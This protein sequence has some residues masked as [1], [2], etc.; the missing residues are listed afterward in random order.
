M[1]ATVTDSLKRK[2]LEVI[3]NEVTNNLERYYVGVGRSDAWDDAGDNPTTP[4]NSV[5][6]EREFRL[7]WQSVKRIVDVS[8][9]VPRHNWT[10]GSIYSRYDDNYSSYPTYPYY[11]LTDDNQVYICLKQSTNDE[12]VANPSTSKP[13]TTNVGT[14]QKTADGYI[15][16][17]LYT[18]GGATANK[19]L[20]A[21]YMPVEYIN[22]SSGGIGL[23]GLQVQ[24]AEVRENAIPKQVLGWVVDSGGR[25]FTSAP[26]IT[27]V[28]N[29]DSVGIDA[30]TPIAGAV[31]TIS[32]SVISKVEVDSSLDSVAAFG[33]NY[34]YA[35]VTLSGGGGTGSVI[36]PILGPDSG[37]GANPVKDLRSASIMFNVKPSGGEDGA[38]GW[39][40]WVVNEQDYRQVALVY[41]PNKGYQQ[42]YAGID[43]AYTEDTG[44]V[45]P[46]L[47]MSSPADAGQFTLDQTVTDGTATGLIVDIDSDRI[48]Y[49]QNIDT[50]FNRFE[51]SRQLTA[52]GLGN[53]DIDSVVRKGDIDPFS[54]EIMYLENRAA[55]ERI[56]GQVEDVKIII[57]L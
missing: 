47:V 56:E 50:G 40:D 42:Y 37:I 3:Y 55:V 23:T 7:G 34:D 4:T 18:I 1:P 19:F 14:V 20:S 10:S 5:L 17:F 30:N 27:I 52:D 2:F 48:Y 33:R 25:D 45:S 32:G 46:Y 53:F 43:S 44:R 21:N 24:Q 9:V 31:A 39:R 6:N 41:S 11:V 15:W 12:G 54:G 49:Q 8:Y 51:K 16:K 29:G 36:R 35:N 22:D 28:G 57:S 38:D 26:T 13:T